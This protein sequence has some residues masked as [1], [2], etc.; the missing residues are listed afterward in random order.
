MCFARLVTHYWRHA[1]WLE[2]GELLRGAHRLAGIPGVLIHGRL[3]VSSPLEVPWQLARSWPGSELVI[4]EQSGHGGSADMTELIVSATDRFASR[5]VWRTRPAPAIREDPSLMSSGAVPS[6]VG[7]S[8]DPRGISSARS[9]RVPSRWGSAGLLGLCFVLLLVAWIAAT[10]PFGSPDEQD[11]YLRAL[12]IAN[13][14]LLGPKVPWVDSRDAAQQAWASKDSRGVSVP[15]ALSPPG[16]VCVDGRPDAGRSGCIEATHTGDYHPLPYL[17]PAL[18]LLTASTADTG[19]WLSR[20][21]SALPCA[22]FILLAVA[23]LWSGSLWSLLG[24]MAAVSPMVLFVGSVVNP[25]GLEIAASITLAAGVLRIS[26]SPAQ[27]PPWVWAA[28]AVSGVT[29]VLSW[30]LGPVYAAMDGLL[31]GGLLGRTGIRELYATHRR[32]LAI[33]EAILLASL[34]A[35]LAYGLS[36]GVLHSHIAIGP[37]LPGLRLGGHQLGVVLREWVGVFGSENVRQPAVAYWAWWLVML[38]LLAAA[39]AYGSR[40]ER[41]VTVVVTL[42]AIAFPVLFYAWVYRYTGFSLQGRYVIPELALIPLVSGEVIYRSRSR[43]PPTHRE[44]SAAACLAITGG[45]QLVA[46]WTAA[47]HAAGNPSKLWFM[48]HATWSPPLGWWPWTTLAALATI[49]LLIGAAAQ[50]RAR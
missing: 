49:M 24:L 47:S 50:L 9:R 14:Q 34:A 23:L 36:S 7:S 28:I 20:A 1:A 48:N 15:A 22:V 18:A 45:L 13:G 33:S 41:A 42:L 38:A 27:S 32:S 40:R 19:L 3:D 10:R 35:F 30:Q 31:L 29:T 12:S 17:L 2:E 46:W 4:A 44:P 21:A 6:S 25:N 26:R 39:V 43:I 11:H 16:R 37:L 5:S 8:G